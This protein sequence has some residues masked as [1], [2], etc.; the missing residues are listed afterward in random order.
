MRLTDHSGMGDALWFEVGEDLGRFSINEFCLITDMK[1]VGFTHL[2]S[3][4][5]NV[6]FANDDDAVKLSLLYMIF[7]IPLSNENSV[8]I[9]PKFFDLADNLDD[10]N[11]FPWGV[12]SWEAN[13]AAIFNIVENRLPSKRI[14]LKK[15]DKVHYNIAGFPHA[16]LVWAY[17]ALSSIATKFITKYDEAIPRMLSWTTADNVKFDDVKSAFTAVGEKHPKYFVI[18]PTEE[19]LKDPW[20]A[21]LYLKNPKVVPQLPLKTYVPRSSTDTNS[22]WWE[23]QKE[24]RGQVDSMNKKLE[25]LK[26]GQK[27]STKLLRRV[28]KLLSNNMNEKG[29]GKAP[30]AYHVS[31]RQ[32]MNVQ[33]DESDA[34]KTTSND[35]GSGSQDDVFIDSDIG[36]FADMGVQAAMEFLTV[37]KEDVEEEKERPLVECY[38][39]ENNKEKFKKHLEGK[40]GEAKVK[41]DSILEIKEVSMPDPEK[42]KEEEKDDK[43]DMREQEEIKLEEAANEESI[44]DVIPKQKRFRLL[45]LGQRRFG[46]KTEVASPSHAPSKLIY[47]LPPGLANEPPKEKLEEF[48]E[49]INKGLLKRTPPGKRPPR[50]NAK[51]ETLDKPH[52]LGFMAIEKKSWF[53]ELA[54]SPIWL[55]DEHINVA[56]YYLS[57]KIKQ[58]P[59]LVQQKVTTV[60]TFFCAKIGALWRVY[61]ISPDTFD[62][63]SCDSLLKIIL[64]MCVRCGSSWFEVN[65]LLIPI[66][67]ADLKHWAFVKLDLTNW[68]IEVI[69]L[70]EF[71][72]RE[73]PG[74]YPIPVTIMKDI[75]QQA[76]GGDRGMFTIKYAECLIEGRDVRYWVIHG[77]T[78][79]FREWL[80]CY[81]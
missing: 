2:L 28:L 51:Y 49:W 67:L 36:A 22:E 78:Q 55:W 8:K 7:C 70:L 46:P 24:I 54:T 13:R 5:L 71:K 6:N 44:S 75:P 57:K 17:E 18:M 25:D 37:D 69:S 64:G 72:P 33:T 45:R 14:P 66:H 53:Y 43:E 16:L 68:T 31:S 73:P 80:T 62:W 39:G 20:V 56:F 9:D 21:Q 23:F 29:Q 26:K 30:T 3:E 63:G 12:L 38:K 34:L 27:K 81:L 77:G 60:D 48:R 65:T 40:E 50:Y 4:L 47:A 10:F 79:I 35:L 1:C 61:Q 52:D 76:N 41:S 42:E 15:S 19:E 59:E 32:K 58:F 74:I 11:D